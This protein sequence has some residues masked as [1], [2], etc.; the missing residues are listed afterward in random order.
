M[1]KH[2]YTLGRGTYLSLNVE[3][4]PYSKNIGDGPIKWL[5]LLL[6]KKH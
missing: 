1:T 5:F 3:E 2:V 4:S 6:K